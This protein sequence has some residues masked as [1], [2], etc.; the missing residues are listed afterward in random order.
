VDCRQLP[1]AGGCTYYVRSLSC[2]WLEDGQPHDCAASNSCID[3]DCAGVETAFALEPID[4]RIVDARATFPDRRYPAT[5]KV[6]L[7]RVVG[8]GRGFR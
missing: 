7:Y 6:G 1:R 4:E 8:A 3:A 5:A 2:Y